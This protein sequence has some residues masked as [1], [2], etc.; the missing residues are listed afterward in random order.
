MYLGTCSACPIHFMMFSFQFERTLLL[1][2][3]NLHLEACDSFLHAVKSHFNLL[4][5]LQ[6]TCNPCIVARNTIFCFLLDLELSFQLYIPQACYL[7]LSFFTYT[8]EKF[9]VR[10]NFAVG[11]FLNFDCY[12]LCL[13]LLIQDT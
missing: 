4:E 13:C 2:F 11:Q 5:P 1:A 7:Y 12:F 10:Y 9:S 8:Y 6:D 3:K